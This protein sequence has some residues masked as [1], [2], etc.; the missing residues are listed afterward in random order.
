MTVLLLA[1]FSAVTLSHEV[2]FAGDYTNQVYGI[3]DPD[4]I[5]DPDMW[6]T[7]DIETEARSFW[8][9]ALGAEKGGT[10]FAAGN[11]LN[12]STRSIREALTLDF[13]QDIM[14]NLELELRNCTELCY[15]HHALPQ[16][17]DTGF[18]TDYWSNVSQLE[19]NLDVTPTLTISASDQAQ[20]FHY[21]QPDS[22]NYGYLLNRASA[23]LRQELG[24]IS[25]VTVD[26]DW[27]RRWAS[28]ADDQDY[29]GHDLD[30]DLDWYCDNGPHLGLS[31]SAGRR[32]Y[33]S[34]SR[35]YWEESPS[36]RLGVDVSPALELILDEEARWAWYDSPTEVYSNLFENR[37]KLEAEWRA[38]PEFNLRAGPQ[39]DFGRGL[40]DATSD[41]YREISTSAGVDYMK[42]DRLWFS[43]EDR[44]GL[45]RYPLADSSFQSNYL[46]NEFNLMVN[47]T[48][49][50]TIGGGLFLNGMVALSP[51]W[52][53]DK[54]SDLST[55]IFT[56]ELKYGL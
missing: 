27:S 11:D 40:P 6:D 23:G 3:V 2:G 28:A 44:L 47:W 22:Y 17:A 51:E 19:L 56:L 26:Y 31:N 35:S 21:P 46:F 14:S 4:T 49:L 48:I 33:A 39:Y 45:R 15:Y 36:L 43:I 13:G 16:L 1:L 55:R 12:L 50:K 30:V 42:L 25:S 7:L 18:Q 10:R 41:D 37:L 54:S 24:G 32:R 20:L 9:F 52:H 8:S 5:I 34:A 53:A 29:V 38:T